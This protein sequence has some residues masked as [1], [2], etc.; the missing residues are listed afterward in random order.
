MVCATRNASIGNSTKKKTTNRFT[1]F[2]KIHTH[3]WAISNVKYWAWTTI[4]LGSMRVIFLLEIKQLIWLNLELE[5]I[6]LNEISI[7]YEC[8]ENSGF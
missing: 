2:R 8:I 4:Q 5:K 6:E 7:W 3:E 1:P